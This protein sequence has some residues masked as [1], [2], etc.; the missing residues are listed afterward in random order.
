MPD[1]TRFVSARKMRNGGIELELNS[2][3]AAKW[4]RGTHTS[5]RLAEN[6]GNSATIKAPG[7]AVLIENAPLYFNPDDDDEVTKVAR[8]NSWEEQDIIRVRW[9]KDPTRRH[10]QQTSAHREDR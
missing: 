10:L 4:A 6:F 7:Y 9:I 2:A 1:G 5:K 3:E 8:A